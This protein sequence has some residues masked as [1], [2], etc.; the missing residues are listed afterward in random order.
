MVFQGKKY[1]ICPYYGSRENV[2]DAEILCVPYVSLFHKKTREKFG[3][4]LKNSVILVDEAHNLLEAI[5]QIHSFVFNYRQICQIYSQLKRYQD[6][7]Q[8]RLKAKNAFYVNQLCLFLNNLRIFLQAKHTANKP[9]TSLKMKILDFLLEINGT[10][11][12]FTKL[13]SFIENSQLSKK[14]NM[15]IE[16]LQENIE[17]PTNLQ[18]AEDFIKTSNNILDLFIDFFI[19]L[20]KTNDKESCFLIKFSEKLPE[21]SINLL[22]LDPENAIKEVIKECHSIVLAGGTMEPISD[23]EFI[24][25]LI[26]ANKYH[27]FSCGHIISQQQFQAFIIKKYKESGIDMVYNYESKKNPELLNSTIAIIQEI[28]REIPEGL[29]IFVQSY[30]FLKEMEEKLKVCGIID[31][32]QGKKLFFDSKNSNKLIIEYEKEINFPQS[33]G[34]ILFSVM[35]GRLSEGINFNDKL[36][37]G[38]I[39]LGLPFSN[40]KSPEIIEKTRFFEKKGVNY[41][42]NACM[43][44]VNQTI[45]RAI[46]HKNDYAVVFLVDKRF[47]NVGIQEKLPSW[48][49]GYV[50][51]RINFQDVLTKTQKFF[52]LLNK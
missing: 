12:D 28:A 10:S 43:K 4:N 41:Q 47:E 42:E 29:I 32:I 33:K 22:R 3:I 11:L 49:R 2:K 52:K 19:G 25:K 34:A 51:G 1:G 50:E 40:I 35:G 17:T 8:K 15:F 38:I 24:R 37:R 9:G 16:K 18:I 45:G 6:K 14:L 26:P 46:R 21:S 23:Y 36:A 13:Q 39:V 30:G 20:L 5:C 44:L 31:K 48:I 7:Y 27:H